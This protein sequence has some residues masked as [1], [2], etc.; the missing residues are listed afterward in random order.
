[1]NNERYNV[2]K[3]FKK[4]RA[5]TNYRSNYEHLLIEK[6]TN[7]IELYKHQN[8]AITISLKDRMKKPNIVVHINSKDIN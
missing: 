8:P 6:H 5:L 1:M 3:G 2:I 7:H 4:Q